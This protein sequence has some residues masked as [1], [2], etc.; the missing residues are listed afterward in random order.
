MLNHRALHQCK[1]ENMEDKST[2]KTAIGKVSVRNRQSMIEIPT[3]GVTLDLS[4][5]V[6][7]ELGDVY[8]SIKRHPDGR[9]HFF[10]N[11]TIQLEPARKQ[12]E[13]QDERIESLDQLVYIN[14]ELAEV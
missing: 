12:E 2:P 10:V 6:P 4:G 9:L 11:G 1:Q 7:K 3:E 5:V 14:G 8:A 13:H